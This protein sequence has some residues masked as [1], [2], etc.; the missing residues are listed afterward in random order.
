MNT[1]RDEVVS[2]LRRR[3]DHDRA[4]RATCALPPHVDTDR[5]RSALSSLGVSP[6]TLD[7][8]VVET[9]EE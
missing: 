7:L 5:D 9:D 6:D 4:L 3:G 2:A 1:E 8:P